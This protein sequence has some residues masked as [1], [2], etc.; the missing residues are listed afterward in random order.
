MTTAI[1][2]R[3]LRLFSALLVM[4]QQH[5]SGVSWSH[6]LG[7]YV[8]NSNGRIVSDAKIQS[9][10][11]NIVDEFHKNVERL[12]ERLDNGNLTI[13]QWQERMK[14]EILDIHRTQYTVG[15]GGV[16][17]MTPRDWGR[18]GSDLRWMHYDSLDGF[19]LDI[20][21]GKQ[22]PDGTF[23]PYTE[24]EI[25]A[26]SKLYMNSSNKQYWRGKTEAKIAAGYVTEQRF[27]NPAEHCGDCTGYAAQGRVPIGTLPPPGED[28]EC[29]AN[30]KCT[31]KFYKA[32]E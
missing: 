28:S 5:R 20:S 2:T 14:Q 21:N 1:N 11:D 25:R 12:A 18:L 22:L 19:A 4:L 27:L 24:S 31:M 32:G 6:D 26:R 9:Q 8:W 7:A 29:Q 16:D 17:Q 23:R 3:N 13:A 10:L 30:C 15:R